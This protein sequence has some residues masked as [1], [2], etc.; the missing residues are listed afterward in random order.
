M[1]QILQ[2]IVLRYLSRNYHKSKPLSIHRLIRIMERITGRVVSDRW[3]YRKIDRMKSERLV[4]EVDSHYSYIEEKARTF[5]TDIPLRKE[6]NRQ[7]GKLLLRLPLEKVYSIYLLFVNEPKGRLR[8]TKTTSEFE[9]A[10]LKYG[11][12]VFPKEFKVNHVP[13]DEKPHKKTRILKQMVEKGLLETGTKN[14]YYVLESSTMDRLIDEQPLLSY[15]EI[16]T[17]FKQFDAYHLGFFFMNH[18]ASDMD[19]PV[20][21]SR[22]KID[23]I[24]QIILDDTIED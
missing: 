12:E 1:Y 22:R 19:R 11:K 15:E 18:I 14:G 13:F 24:R 10:V 16:G 9:Q 3:V 17:I 7:L 20:Q 8:M 4:Y 21:M 2:V 6:Q 23:M 5:I